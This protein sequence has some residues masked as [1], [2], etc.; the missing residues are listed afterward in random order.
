[1]TGLSIWTPVGRFPTRWFRDMTYKP[2]GVLG[3]MGPAAT[4]SFM[5]RII[6][7]T[8]VEDDAEHIPLLVDMN[9]QIPSRIDAILKSTENP[10]PVLARMATTL[11][12]NGAQALTMPCNTA[13]YYADFIEGAVNIPLLNM[14]TLAANQIKASIGEGKVGML[15]SPLTDQVGIFR[16]AFKPAGLSVIFPEDA[17]YV[18]SIIRRIKAEG[19]KA[20]MGQ[21][22]SELSQEMKERGAGCLL[23]GC[24]E[25]SLLTGQVKTDLPIFDTVDILAREAIRFSG[26]VL[27]A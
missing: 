13:H 27:K 12:Q 21:K 19:L 20:D 3:G 9:P 18:L 5:Q 26:G 24:S 23:I 2:I 15:A 16:D 17:D 10:G 8:Q 22:L 6:D 25:F 7:L 1:M 14:L 4:A 11:E